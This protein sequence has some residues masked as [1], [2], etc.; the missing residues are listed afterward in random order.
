ML[1]TPLGHSRL[2]ARPG[3]WRLWL[4]NAEAACLW[5]WYQSALDAEALSQCLA[6]H[7]GLSAH[8]A[9]DQV[10]SVLD[11]WRASG[12]LE[13]PSRLATTTDP[14]ESRWR[15]AATES[16]PAWPPGTQTLQIADLRL[17]LWIEDAA[18]QKHL[19]P[20]MDRLRCG[21]LPPA[22]AA[23]SP[24]PGRRSS[25]SSNPAPLLSLHGTVD[26]WQLR[27]N[28]Q[29]VETGA[30]LDAAQRAVMR[31]LTESGC[32]TAERLLVVHG[33]GV[34]SPDGTGLLLIGPGGSGK[35]TLAAAL[36]ADGLSLLH[37]DVVPVDLD[38]RLL[39]LGLP[40]TLKAGSW[41][42]L[43]A[44]RPDLNQIPTRQR[45]GQPVRYLPPVGLTP[46][47]PIALGCFIFP[48]Y[49]PGMP[50]QAQRLSPEAAL[51]GLIEAEAVIRNITQ[52]RLQRLAR[53]L[54]S[55]SAWS[56]TYPDLA[57]GLTA[58]RNLQAQTPIPTPTQHH[59][60]VQSRTDGPCRA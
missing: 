3:Y 60:P 37:D 12:L 55:A 35:T 30:S 59:H 51:Q 56:L 23:P 2:L 34:V 43:Q 29:D 57:S 48:R 22:A 27:W 41:P 5:D 13:A 10:R 46:T 40:I 25:S 38:G 18:L 1:H 21:A 7:T 26:S 50:V 53:W 8:S 9:R 17:G 54:E 19:G 39:G 31:E 6:Q 49:Q 15:Q 36:N 4:L 11:G 52:D 28:G 32:R 58:V 16:V 24:D 33:A 42:V 20:G 47:K 14:E 45:L 44:L